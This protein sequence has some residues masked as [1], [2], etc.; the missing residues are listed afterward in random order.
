MQPSCAILLSV[1][2][3]SREAQEIGHMTNVTIKTTDKNY[4]YIVEIPY[5]HTTAKVELEGDRIE[6]VEIARK[7]LSEDSNA[8][9]HEAAKQL[10]KQD[11]KF[12]FDGWLARA[13]EAGL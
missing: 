3:H 7:R 12:A 10:A 8:L 4:S 11:K 6:F 13:Q 9:A 5:E 2:T 1:D